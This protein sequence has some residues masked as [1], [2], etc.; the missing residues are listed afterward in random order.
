SLTRLALGA[1]LLLAPAAGAQTA[2]DLSSALN[3]LS[4]KNA[5]ALA[6][7]KAIAAR[8]AEALADGIGATKDVPLVVLAARVAPDSSYTPGHLCSPSDPN[9]KEY[10]YAEHIPYCNRN[11]TQQMKLTIAA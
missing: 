5:D 8:Q 11:V 10:R 7:Q 9:F 3:D 6:S 1:A 4:S 2:P